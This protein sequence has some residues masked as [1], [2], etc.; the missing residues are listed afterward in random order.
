[1][2]KIFSNGPDNDFVINPFTRLI[3]TSSHLRFATPY[4]T[5]S[6][7]LLEAAGKGKTVELLIGLNEAT[8]PRA[9]RKLHGIP[10]I[11]IRY[12][13]SRF[14]AKI[15]MFDESVLLGSSNLTDGG[16][17]SNREAVIQ[18]DWNDDAEAVDDLRALFVELWES[19]FVLTRE[20]LDDFERTFNELQR[21]VSDSVQTI[22]AV[23]GRAQPHNINVASHARSRERIFLETLR[24]KVYEEYY[25]AFREVQEILDTQE[26]RRSDFSDV[27]IANET[28]R[29]L[30]YVR[31]TH[32]NGDDAWQNAPLR[33]ADDRREQIMHHAREWVKAPDSKAPEDY[34]AWLETVKRVFG[35][36]EA[37]EKS[38]REDITDGLMSVHAF[39]ER[40]R[41]V[42]GGR[43]NL[44]AAFWKANKEDVARVKK[45][46]IYL[47]HEPGD[48]IQRL[49]DILYDPSMKLK[50][51][52][53]FCALELY[54]T[55]KPDKCPPMNGRTAKVLRYL[56]FDV[57]GH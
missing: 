57:K 8:S 5:R 6:D 15:Y 12:F 3:E 49:H 47:L 17:M 32:V 54:G 11:T 22:E 42:K 50:E 28:N 24:H 35:T 55:V 30:N 29:F 48:F 31:L 21:S 37:I 13:T 4:F 45:T 33:N 26:L 56:G 36:P 18:L 34:A 40:F 53:Y 41:F 51:F 27:G 19:G 44:P 20:K 38:T 46:L 7:L 16:L 52:G 10:N 23:L 25:P 39:D 14:H 43:K 1:M 2:N 9:L